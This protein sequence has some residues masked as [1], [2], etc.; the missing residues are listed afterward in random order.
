L[1]S[2]IITNFVHDWR[3][4]FFVG[5][6]PALLAI[7]LQ[8]KLH[9]PE[10]WQ[11][12]K[13]KQSASEAS[14]SPLAQLFGPDTRKNVFIGSLAFG[15]LLIGYWA[16][17]SWIPTWIHD[18]LG[19][20]GTGTEKSIATIYHAVAAVLGC[21]AS[22]VLANAIGRRGTI[23]LSGV[24]AFVASALLFLT[25]SAFSDI[26]Y[27]Q[28]AMLG[29]FI[30]LMQAVMYIYL[31]ELFPT[32]VRATAVGFC[33]NAGRASAAVAALYV[34]SLVA[35]F[36]GYA[37]ALMAFSVPYLVILI[38]AWIGRETRHEVLPD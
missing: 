9:E 17:L 8:T 19:E 36:G 21:L 10:K 24:G 1:L 15:A 31:P 37:E 29:F 7:V 38:A 34:G 14:A 27:W 22:G 11:A 28:D 16:S 32:R 6:A 18:L 26:I 12:D 4:V 30:G 25:N 3:L 5:A 2:G 23:M 35:F 20:S 13:A 33:L